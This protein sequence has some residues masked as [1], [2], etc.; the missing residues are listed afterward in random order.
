M[1]HWPDLVVVEPV[2]RSPI[3]VEVEL[4]PKSPATIRTILRAYRQANRRIQIPMSSEFVSE[5]R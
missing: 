1:V 2:P 3:A 5:S 4:T